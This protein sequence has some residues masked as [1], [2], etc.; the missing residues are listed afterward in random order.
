MLN[1]MGAKISGIGSN[2]LTI[3]GVKAPLMLT[4]MTQRL[5]EIGVDY[6]SAQMLHEQ[7]SINAAEIVPRALDGCIDGT[8]SSLARRA[9]ESKTMTTPPA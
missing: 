3:E 5:Q 8:V 1:R 9:T 2:L 6:D 4:R 7:Q